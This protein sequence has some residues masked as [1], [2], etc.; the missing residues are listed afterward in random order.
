MINSNIKFPNE[1]ERNDE[2]RGGIHKCRWIT[3]NWCGIF[4]GIKSNSKLIQ[5]QTNLLRS[6]AAIRLQRSNCYN[7]I[8][9]HRIFGNG[10]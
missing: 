1:C 7:Q 4:H 8:D 6:D 2:K 3:T 9:E 5:Y 10:N